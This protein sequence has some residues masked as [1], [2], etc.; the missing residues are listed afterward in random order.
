MTDDEDLA[1]KFR[2]F[3]NYG[4]EKK[5]HNTVVGCNSR[6]DELQAGLLRVKLTHMDE[7]NAERNRIAGQ[8]LAEITNP[9]VNLPQVRPRADSTW[10][11][12]V[13]HTA[14]RDELQEY[15]TGRGIG[16]MIHY[17]IPPHLSEAYRYLGHQRGDFPIAE[18]YADEVLSLP[19]Y[20][21][22]TKEEQDEVIRAVN[23]FYIS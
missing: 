19:V 5:Y 1:N 14:L 12:F 3:R 7:L 20:N 11:Q 2:V 22:M 10:H 18:R 23:E 13:I 21:G 16:T 17:P 4:S 8:Y 6:L 15:L 9:Y